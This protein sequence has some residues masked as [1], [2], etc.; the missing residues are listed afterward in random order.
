MYIKPN[1]GSF[2]WWKNLLLEVVGGDCVCVGGFV[3]ARTT[4]KAGSLNQ[5]L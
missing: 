4:A 1:L 5:F 3:Q 2:I